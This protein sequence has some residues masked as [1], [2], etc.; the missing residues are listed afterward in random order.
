MSAQSLSAARVRP[1]R[2][3]IGC[4]T[5][6]PKPE[7]LRLLVPAGDEKA[8][9]SVDTGGRGGGRGA[10]LCR[11]SAADCLTRARRRA[12]ARALRTTAERVDTE[13]LT[14][15]VAAATAEHPTTPEVS[16]SP[17]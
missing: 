1:E 9:V 16:S 5:T 15:A 2:T 13:A 14:A 11:A 12:L 7:L 10:Y 17:R 4:R 8:A 3:C 6:R